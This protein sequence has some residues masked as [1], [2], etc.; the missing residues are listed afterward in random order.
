MSPKKSFRKGRGTADNPPNRFESLVYQPDPETDDQ[1]GT[2]LPTIR[3]FRDPSRTILAYNKSPDVGFTVSFNPYRG[4]EHGCIYC[5]SGDTLVLMADGSMQKLEALTVGDKIYGT[6]RHGWYR[7]YTKTR[8]LA[9]WKTQK[10]AFKV[11]LGDG[12]FLVAS[13]DHRFLTERGWKYVTGSGAGRERRPH[14]TAGN[15]LMGFGAAFAVSP[16]TTKDYEVGYLCG[17]I[18]GDGHINFYPYE[19]VGRTHGHQYRFRLAMVDGEA[20]MRAAVYLAGVGVF[21]KSF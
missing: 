6:E 5:L 12:T 18:R 14:L 1:E 10:P 8:V 21:T 19:R 2:S 13:G 16:V 7:R 11:T 15:K 20:L 4:C 9:H 17:V 3:L